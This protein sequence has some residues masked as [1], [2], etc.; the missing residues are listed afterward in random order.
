[1]K[2][3]SKLIAASA[4]AVLI[5][6]GTVT[7]AVAQSA[8]T[9]APVP[10]IGA[11][12]EASNS[13]TESHDRDAIEQL[14]YMVELSRTVAGGISQ[15]F[16]SAQSMTSLLGM[17][18]D[19]TNSQLQA[20]TGV[21]TIPM[22]NGTDEVSARDGG[23]GLLE[24]ATEGLEGS[25]SDPPDI[26]DVFSELVTTYELEKVF[27]YKD[28]ERLNEVTMAHLTSY[29]A[30]TASS[31]DRTYKRAN[32]SMARVDDY[33]AALGASPDLKTSLDLN[34]RVN[35]EVAQQLNELIRTQSALS[36]LAGMYIVGTFSS[37]TDIAD[38]FNLK[39][40]FVPRD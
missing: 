21:K 22:A 37:R 18:R 27:A 14:M 34:T 6:A 4:L 24:M 32:E 20:V 26:S 40:L 25:V 10:S 31:A 1:M 8:V 35:I 5:P 23:P 2:T 3:F 13:E 30:L 36:S 39:R 9:P 29:G 15:I 17:I 33:I 19:V 16:S 12:P 38:N 11:V 28:E 7:T